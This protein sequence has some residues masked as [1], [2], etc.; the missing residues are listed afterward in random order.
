MSMMG[1]VVRVLHLN[2]CPSTPPTISL[3]ERVANDLGI[4]VVI[5][6]VTISTQEE[7]V[8]HR[9]IGSPTVQVEG[10]DIDPSAR[11]EVAFGMT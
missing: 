1:I 8:R 3:I 7:A 6:E 10:V 9:H 4:D 5:E 11:Q 2:G